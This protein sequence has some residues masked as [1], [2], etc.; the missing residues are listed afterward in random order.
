MMC[1]QWDALFHYLKFSF[2]VTSF[3]AL[4][5][6][7][8]IQYRLGLRNSEIDFVQRSGL[9]DASAWDWWMGVDVHPQYFLAEE[10][11]NIIIR[12]LT[13]VQGGKGCIDGIFLIVNK[14]Y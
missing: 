11:S 13:E 1:Q 10:Y 7:H 12:D 4:G 8:L 5:L 3:S 9:L 14:W 6:V 2:E